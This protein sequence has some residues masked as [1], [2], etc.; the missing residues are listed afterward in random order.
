MALKDSDDKV[1]NEFGGPIGA[2]LIMLWSHCWM[3]YLW[4]SLEFYQGGIFIPDLLLIPSQLQKASPTLQSILVYWGFMLIQIILAITL[5]GPKV[6][7]LPVPSEKNIQY[8]YLCNAIS[9]WYF[10]LILYG[11]LHYFGFLKI[12]YL[13]DNM[14]SLM[15]TA[16]IS[17]DLLSVIIYYWGILSKKQI[18]MSGNFTYDFFMGS[19]LNPR[20]GILDLK[21][22]AEIRASWMQLFFLTLS[23]ALKQYENIGYVS[24][25]MIVILIAHGLY[26][27]A[28]MKGEECVP[29]TWDIFYEKWG[30]MLIFWNIA[31]VPYV[32]CFQSMYLLKNSSINNS[33]IF[34]IILLFILFLAYY[35]W[36]SSQSQKNRFRMQLR[37]TYVKRWSFP[38]LPWGTLTDPEYIKTESG[39]TLLIGGWWKYARKIHYTCDIFMALVWALSCGFTGLLPFFYPVFFFFM[40]LHRY[41]RDYERCERKYGDD[42]K[43]YCNKVPYVFIPLV[44]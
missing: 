37:G 33:L 6:K 5:P 19:W 9:S 12:T 14:G 32:Y 18:R 41:K 30:W 36:D 23:A 26:A 17:G 22:F 11:F 27:N 44:Y 3:Y 1:V 21:M 13:A 4:L 38:Q 34:T 40:I 16:I 8:E 25:S 31:G 29:T 20:I 24:N 2:L 42:W 15:T 39:S 43:K 7:G 35:I 10:T 28:C